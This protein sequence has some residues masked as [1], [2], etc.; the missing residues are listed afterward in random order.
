MSKRLLSLLTY[1]NLIL[2]ARKNSSC[3]GRQ[4]EFIRGTSQVRVR[5]QIFFLFFFF[6]F[7][8]FFSDYT[9]DLRAVTRNINFPVG[10]IFGRKSHYRCVLYQSNR[11][12]NIPPPRATPRAFE[13]LE[14]FCSNSPLPRP[15][16]CSNAPS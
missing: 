13:F 15:K 7:L 2:T 3:L 11:S 16:S 5:F 9:N 14:K 1:S 8:V 6:S 10:D 4:S 12:L